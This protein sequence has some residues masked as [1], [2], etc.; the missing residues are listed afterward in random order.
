MSVGPGQSGKLDRVGKLMADLKAD[1]IREDGRIEK[2]CIHGIGHTVGHVDSKRLTSE[3]MWVH[4]CDG[5]CAG[6]EMQQC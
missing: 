1:L 2:L 4:G 5:C 3:Y 6:W